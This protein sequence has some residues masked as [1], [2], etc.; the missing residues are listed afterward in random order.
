MTTTIPTEVPTKPGMLLEYSRAWQP[1]KVNESFEFKKPLERGWLIPYLLQL[2]GMAAGRWWHWSDMMTAGK[3]LDVPIP[4]CEFISNG[5]GQPGWRV[6]ENSLECINRSSGWQGWGSWNVFEYFLD[7]LLYGF[8][9]HMVMELPKDTVS[10]DGRASERLYQVFDLAPLLAFPY[11][12]WGDILAENNFGRGNGFFPTPLDICRMMVAMQMGDSDTRAK[13]V[14]DPCVGTG[15]M[16]LAA[17]N[18]SYRLFGNDI[19]LTVIKAT[20]VNGY[21][22]APWLVKPFPFWKEPS[23]DTSETAPMPEA[24]ETPVAIHCGKSLADSGKTEQL[25]LI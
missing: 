18:H 19:N 13:T 12:Y 6:L 17:S 14:C 15:R 7:W 8:G 24:T 16:L 1:R 4:Q 2:E 11:D 23:S 3:M 10:N 25:T 9:C 20:L 5:R 21:L 22:Y